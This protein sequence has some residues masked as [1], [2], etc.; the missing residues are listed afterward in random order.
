MWEE[1]KHNLKKGFF[2]NLILAVQFAVL[3]WQGTNIASYFLDLP[4]T[5]STEN[6]RGDSAYYSLHYWMSSEEDYQY[7][8]NVSENPDYESNR[9]PGAYRL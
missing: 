3:F 7:A 1:L 4:T 5:F 6:I 2:I 8:G 9:Y